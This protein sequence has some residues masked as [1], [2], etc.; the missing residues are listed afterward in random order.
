[1]K[2]TYGKNVYDNKEI[3]A[4]SNLAIT[5]YNNTINFMLVNIV[6]FVC[7]NQAS[8]SSNFSSKSVLSI[9]VLNEE[10]FLTVK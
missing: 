6:L 5:F 2:I 7:I 3:K 9:S 10:I 8:I 4:L 1:M